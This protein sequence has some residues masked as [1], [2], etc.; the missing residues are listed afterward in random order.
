MQS[1]QSSLIDPTK[2]TSSIHRALTNPPE[3]PVID[4]AQELQGT[5]TFESPY[6]DDRLRDTLSLGRGH[7][8]SRMHIC[9][10]GS[11]FFSCAPPFDA[12]TAA[13]KSG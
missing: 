13:S 3:Y 12:C 8:V 11:P 7:A 9:V 2:N 1:L 10:L 6:H 5:V 4:K